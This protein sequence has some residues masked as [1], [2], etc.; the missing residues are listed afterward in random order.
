[1]RAV[2]KVTTLSV[3]GA[4]LPVW[5]I[6]VGVYSQVYTRVDW[7][8]FTWLYYAAGVSLLAFIAWL[9]LMLTGARSTPR[10]EVRK[11]ADPV[12]PSSPKPIRPAL[13]EY[14]KSTAL[15]NP[16][17]AII[18]AYLAIE[19]WY[20]QALQDHDLSPWNGTE[21][22][23]VRDMSR[24]AAH[25]GFLPAFT[26]QTIDGLG[27]LRDDAVRRGGD[28]ITVDEAQHYLLQT[29]GALL[30]LDKLVEPGG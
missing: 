17:A 10:N 24:I 11:V 28:S 16:L 22:R 29:E 15:E 18:K 19:E 6:A 7:W 5:G 1:M 4:F 21:K 13:T 9:V 14:Y 30:S 23:S 8:P 3:A 20:D 12:P 26:V 27:Y 25:E 2:F